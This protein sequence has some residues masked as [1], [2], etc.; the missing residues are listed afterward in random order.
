MK[1]ARLLFF[2]VLLFAALFE[3]QAQSDTNKVIMKWWLHCR[4]Q[5]TTELNTDT[6]TE[7][8]IYS[9]KPRV[10]PQN[11]QQVQP[12]YDALVTSTYGFEFG[13]LSEDIEI[14]VVLDDI[15]CNNGL[16]AADS[17]GVRFFFD[18]SINVLGHTGTYFLNPGKNFMFKINKTPAFYN[19]LQ[20]SNISADS[21]L[22]FAYST[23]N[24]LGL[25]TSGIR[26]ENTPAALESYI[27]HFSKV[28]GTQMYKVTS[29]SDG[30]NNLPGN[31][32]LEQNYPNPF[33]P[34]TN[35]NFS[36]PEKSNVQLKVFNI[37]GMEIATIYSGQLEA[38]NHTFKFDASKLS[39]GMYLYKLTAG[40][41]VQTRKMLLLK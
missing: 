25:D 18:M 4:N 29:V 12:L 40:N 15:D 14:W 39:S 16:Y 26:T 11:Y 30:I 13:A 35:I 8:K 22:I 10:V 31:Y 2:I 21:S 9:V 24:S 1:K 38:G 27:S 19:F 37:V 32:S 28:V 20:A 33:N 5:S 34:S 6:L 3:I 36:L 23:A 41:F 17:T 7:G